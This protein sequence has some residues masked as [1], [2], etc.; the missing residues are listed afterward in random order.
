MQTKDTGP[1]FKE[2]LN[3]RQPAG[4]ARKLETLAR[5]YGRSKSDLVRGL[6]G[7][8]LHDERA[9]LREARERV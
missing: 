5:I 9:T 8:F 3:I 7:K 4:T 6:V 1:L 2:Q